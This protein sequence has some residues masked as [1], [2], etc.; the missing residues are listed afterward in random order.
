[1]EEKLV[2]THDTHIS[3]EIANKIQQTGTLSLI[4]K[5]EILPTKEYIKYT[6]IQR[7]KNPPEQRIIEIVDEKVDPLDVPKFRYKKVAPRQVSEPVP[8]LH[9]PP[10]KLTKQ[11]MD[12]F[13]IPP[14]ISNWK[15]NRGYT[16]SLDK[17]VAV[18]RRN[19]QKDEINERHAEFAEALYLAEKAAQE[20]NEKKNEMK[21]RI[22]MAKKERNEEEMRQLALAMRK[23]RDEEEDDQFDEQKEKRERAR[24]ERRRERE[25]F[26]RKAGLKGLEKEME[27]EKRRDV[28]ESIALG[29]KIDSKD[30]MFDQRLFNQG[31]GLN[32]GFGEEDEYNVYDEVLFKA[33]PNQ[34]YK[35]K[36]L[37]DE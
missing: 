13:N 21:K 2:R 12:E 4:K 17:R 18:D 30:L 19:L 5:P 33:A 9:D 6:P 28:T 32:S 10:K 35:P 34:Q 11:Q 37:T 3:K 27:R 26:Y 1:M 16:I 23:L 7:G 8:I 22:E 31:D 29:K 15:N 24:D 20:E 25:E 14:C 36:E